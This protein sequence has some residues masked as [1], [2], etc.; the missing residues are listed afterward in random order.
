MLNK[1][2]QTFMGCTAKYQ[3]AKIVLMGAPF[4]TTS[5]FRPGARFGPQAIRAES[6]G[7][8]M[9]SPYQDKDLSEKKI[10]D[11]GDV[12]VCYGSA[13]RMVDSVYRRCKVVHAENKIPFVIGGEHLVSLGAVSAASEKYGGLA[14]IH[15]DAHADLREDYLGEKLSHATV[16]RRCH[17]ILGDGKIYQFGIR[18]GDKS[19]F[20]WSKEGHTHLHKYDFDTL[21]EVIDA[22]QGS[23]VYLTVDMDV[24]DTAVFPGT[25]TPEPGGVSFDALRQAVERVCGDCCIVGCDV[26]ELSPNYDISGI[27]TAAAA[28]LIR[29]MLLAIE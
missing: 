19:E 13:E 24:L 28:K 23:P 26:V 8:E 15:F 12:E 2:V 3:E 5:S 9:Y 16:I 11:S 10:F 17:D 22:L 6:E 7:L 25:G 27:S 1:N 29:E 18:S 20:T 14:L 4:D 21:A